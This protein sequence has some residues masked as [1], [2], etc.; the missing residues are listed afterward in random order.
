M[1]FIDQLKQLSSRVSEISAKLTTE[2][3]TKNAL[4]LP[5]FRILG[6]DVFNPEEFLPEYTAD[7]GIKKGE[8]VDYAIMKDG[9]PVVLI[10][11][12]WC[13]ERLEGHDSQLFRYFATRK[14]K[15]AILTNG[16]IYRFFTDLDEPNKMDESPF[17][18]VDIRDIKETLV[19]E[20]KRFHKNSLD[21]DS[22]SGVAS[23]LK[24]TS[25]I[26]A[27]LA[28]QASEPDEDF[29]NFII[30]KVSYPGRRTAQVVD[31]FTFITKRSFVQ[32]VND[33]LN[34]RFKSMMETNAA[35]AAHK[36]ENIEKAE[37]TEEKPKV[38]TTNE[39]ME[40]YIIIRTLLHDTVDVGRVSY[41]DGVSYFSIL[42][43]GKPRKCICRI[44]LS[45]KKHYL[46]FPAL[47][48]KDERIAFGT[49]GELVS[50][51]DQLVDAAA[52][53]MAAG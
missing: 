23:D 27:M 6:Y 39:E 43:D 50:F 33:L 37:A 7:V 14:A 48:E 1:D 40:A 30:K 3:A 46:S 52:K 10:E 4:V 35:E 19:P 49:N 44:W 15:L 2:E 17:M 12:K 26:K 34:E 51:K 29:V 31:K 24:Y 36:E 13:G 20:L 21:I 45:G 9:E 41:K 28:K 11:A 5:F 53:L 32:Y 38:E 42:L 8:K 22:I 47:G 18:E 25:A 16:I